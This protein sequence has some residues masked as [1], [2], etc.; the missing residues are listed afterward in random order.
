MLAKLTKKK[1]NNPHHQ[2]KF[3]NK[4]T[5]SLNSSCNDSEISS[6]DSSV[7]RCT[8]SCGERSSVSELDISCSTSDNE[9]LNKLPT[10]SENKIEDTNKI[11][12]NII[13]N[14]NK[15]E[16]QAVVAMKSDNNDQKDQSFKT[17]L[18]RRSILLSN[19]VTKSKSSISTTASKL[20][21]PKAVDVLDNY[22]C[23]SKSTEKMIKFFTYSLREDAEYK[24]LSIS[25][26]TTSRQVIEILLDKFKMK[27]RDSNL[28]YVTMEIII[29]KNGMPVRSAIGLN[30]E[31]CP[32][33]LKACYPNDEIRFVIQS[34]P[35]Y[36][37]RVYDSC[38]M[39]GSL[40]KS[41]II[42]VCT[43]VNEL[44]QLTLNCYHS[45]DKSSNYSL[46]VVSKAGSYQLNTN[47]LPLYVQEKW[48]K[49]NEPYFQLRKIKEINYN[50][51]NKTVSFFLFFI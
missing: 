36:L 27:H 7:S 45:K 24:T 8:S 3:H 19:Q 29:K 1:Q 16:Q 4:G 37:V 39:A 18:K 21:S 9:D 46:F 34:K 15:E 25:K 17:E 11:G 23:C 30:D 51:L 42:D 33:Q 32:V 50:Y 6:S 20:L 41:I 22:D 44:I 38:L 10:N 26:N 43:T 48:D 35:G 2:T 12:N 5:S 14:N 28:F 13:E 40:Y 49:K 31:A 47:E